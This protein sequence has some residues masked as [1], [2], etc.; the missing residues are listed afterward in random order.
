[1]RESH[2]KG[3][4]IMTLLAIDQD[5]DDSALI[6]SIGD[7]SAI[8]QSLFEVDGNLLKVKSTV[9][10]DFFDY[11]REGAVLSY[12]IVLKV[13]DELGLTST[14]QTTI[15]IKDDNEFAPVFTSSTEAFGSITESSPG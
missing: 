14:L 13:T 10:E 2:Q 5:S 1:M 8:V 4:T 3:D 6:Y 12:A 7:S 11:E 15:E 9:A